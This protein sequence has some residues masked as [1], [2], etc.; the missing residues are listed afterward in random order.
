M[1]IPIGNAALRDAGDQ[2]GKRMNAATNEMIQR[3][4]GLVKTIARKMSRKMASIHC[5]YD[6]FVSFGYEGLIDAYKKYDPSKKTKFTTYAGIRIRGAIMDGIR[7]FSPINTRSK[8]DRGVTLVSLEEPVRDEG[9]EDVFI[10]DILAA[11]EAYEPDYGLQE[12]ENIRVVSKAN[13]NPRRRAAG[14]FKIIV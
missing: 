11:P 9:H 8:R 3:H 12:K 5:D 13:K 7:G 14:Y 1:F 6:D 4:M 2:G 10:K